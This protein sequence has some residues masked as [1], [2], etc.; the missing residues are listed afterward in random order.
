MTVCTVFSMGSMG[1]T[2]GVVRGLRRSTEDGEAVLAGSML[3]FIGVTEDDGVVTFVRTSATACTWLCMNGRL[4]SC[5]AQ[6]RDSAIAVW[7][8]QLSG[9]YTENDIQKK[10]ETLLHRVH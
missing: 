1:L 9:G 6:H 10:S 7:H 4:G 8:V 2:S 3:G 5:S